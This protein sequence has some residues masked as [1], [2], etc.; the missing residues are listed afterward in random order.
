[1]DPIISKSIPN[2]IIPDE[3]IS[4]EESTTPEKSMLSKSQKIIVID[5]RKENE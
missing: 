3:K 4:I 5:H 1:L 2:V